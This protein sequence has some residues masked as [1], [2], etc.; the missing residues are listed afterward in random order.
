MCIECLCVCIDCVCVCIECV[1]VC[2]ECV[3][4][5]IESRACTAADIYTHAR[6]RIHA[7]TYTYILMYLGIYVYSHAC[8]SGNSFV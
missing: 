6:V 7:C 1:C 5:C 8:S 2:T 4:V 3:C